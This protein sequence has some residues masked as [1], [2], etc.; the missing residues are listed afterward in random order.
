MR[1]LNY[2]LGTNSTALAIEATN[3]GIE[4][5]I[6]IS[7]DTGDERKSSYRYAS[8]V[9]EP[10]MTKHGQPPITW[11]K[12]IR[13]DGSFVSISQLSLKR[14][15]LPSKAY[16]LAGCTSKWKQQPVDKYLRNDPRVRTHIAGGGLVERWIGYD[17]GEPER[18]E[19]MI[20]KNPQ[21]TK[22]RTRKAK[23]PDGTLKRVRELVVVPH[24]KW[25]CPLVD[26]DMDRNDC[27]KVISGSGLPLPGKSSC[28]MCPSMKKREI[29]E[30]AR[31]SPEEMEAA[32]AIEDAARSSGNLIS[33]KGLG[34]SF[35]WRE[36]L[37]GQKE[38]LSA[39]EVVEPECGCFDGD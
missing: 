15:E 13:K 26:W 25:M 18:A 6:I 31:E 11:V 20:D 17:A 12:W 37:N 33:V 36:F 4:F 5:D 19:R 35:S 16:G 23:N 38:A 8:E 21:P 29:L 10:W 32:L 9:F 34:R 1:V 28:F 2:G 30:M 3:R 24:W 22:S 27:L 39:R 14:R 7:A